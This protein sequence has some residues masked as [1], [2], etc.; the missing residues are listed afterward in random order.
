MGATLCPLPEIVTKYL[1]CLALVHD[2]SSVHV[3]DGR[4]NG[5]V[6]AV[7]IFLMIWSAFLQPPGTS[8][9][10]PVAFRSCGFCIAKAR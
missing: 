8:G 10:I 6:S 5:F 1:H 7:L 4:R 2:L 9:I 3:A